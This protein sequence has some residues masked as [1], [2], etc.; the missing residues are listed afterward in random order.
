MV[1]EYAFTKSLFSNNGPLLIGR[2]A[3]GTDEYFEG[4][5]D[6]IRIYNRALSLDEISEIYHDETEYDSEKDCQDD[7]K[8]ADLKKDKPKLI[9]IIP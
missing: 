6:E 3:P 8:S 7:Y 5:L 2:D 9:H 4:A 1:F